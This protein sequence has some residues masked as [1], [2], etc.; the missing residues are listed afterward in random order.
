MRILPP[1]GVFL[2]EMI[3]AYEKI[4]N[5]MKATGLGI[6]R[7]MLD[8]E[9]LDAFKQY[10]HQQQIQFELGPPG[11]HR[12]NQAERAIQTFKV[13]FISILAGVDDK[14]PL[15]LW[16]HLLEPMELTLNLLCQSKVAP[17]I[18]AFAHVHG[19]HDYMKKPFAPLG[20][21]IQ[22]RVKPEDQKTWD[23]QSDARFSLSTLMQHHQCFQ[24]YIMKTRATRISNT[25]FFKHQ[26]ITN[27]TVLPESHVVAAAQQLATALKG[28]IP[29]GNET[30][31]ALMK[32]SKLFTKIAAAKKQDSKGQG[33]MQ[34]SQSNTGSTTDNSPSKGGSINSKGGLRP[35]G[36]SLHRADF[37]EPVHTMASCT[38]T[39]N[40]FL[41]TVTAV[42][43]A[44]S[45]GLAAQLHLP[46]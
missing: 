43:R 31:E 45:R 36:R 18:S 22:A 2:Q 13:H 26:Y 3:R 20:C 23:T 28:N 6:R 32:V 41:I 5:R 10:I 15:S 44:V 24:V 1:T 16:C 33:T 21:A 8:N 29:A 25:V 40:T 4:I 38:C 19:P 37:C 14:F 7:H 27:P 46:G 17:K 30:A 35:R 42:R 34:Q 12:C 9:A 39:R 11:N